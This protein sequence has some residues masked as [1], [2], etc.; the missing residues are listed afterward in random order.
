VIRRKHH[1]RIDSCNSDQKAQVL[2]RKGRYK[3]VAYRKLTLKQQL[4]GVNAAL[5]SPRTPQQLKEGLKKRAKQLRKQ[6][7]N[8]PTFESQVFEE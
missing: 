3:P 7:K 1:Q 6:I 8:K 4:K 5:K 2:S